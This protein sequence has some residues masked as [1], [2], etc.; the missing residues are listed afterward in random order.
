MANR[1]VSR[2][3]A[4]PS[5]SALPE[6]PEGKDA[7][8]PESALESQFE[9]L[10]RLQEIVT[11]AAG[12]LRGAATAL[13]AGKADAV[14]AAARS[15]VREAM[16]QIAR[17]FEEVGLCGGRPGM[18]NFDQ[19]EDRVDNESDIAMD[20]YRLWSTAAV[21]A[22]TL[23]A[24]ER[25]DGEMVTNEPIADMLGITADLLGDERDLDIGMAGR[26]EQ[27]LMACSHARRTNSTRLARGFEVQA[28]RS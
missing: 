25:V 24:G 26:I 13:Y 8:V 6:N 28:V 19:L 12:L 18:C 11:S 7:A 16:A 2:R 9:A 5:V 1:S 4:K 10:G 14:T 23:Q 15:L 3:K 27:M 21:A 17:A 20:L 22:S